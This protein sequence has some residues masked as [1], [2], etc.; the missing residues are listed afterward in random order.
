MV[1]GIEVVSE[2]ASSTG[3]F[4]LTGV[5]DTTMVLVITLGSV[6]LTVVV[7]AAVVVVANKA[8]VGGG[9]IALGSGSTWG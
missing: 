8:S 5:V 2:V 3:G 4:G 7:V 1:N 9:G 6:G